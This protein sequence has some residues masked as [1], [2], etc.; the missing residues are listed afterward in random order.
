V[1][2]AGDID[3]D[4]IHGAA[5]DG[6]LII[7]YLLGFTGSQLVQN[8]NRRRRQSQ[9]SGRGPAYLVSIHTQLDIDL[10]GQSDPLTDGLLIA[11]YLLGLRGER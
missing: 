5:T 1:T 11:R 8:A 3:L 7:R 6:V 10:N 4:G 9:R 2:N